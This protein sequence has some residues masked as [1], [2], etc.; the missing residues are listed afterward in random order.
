MMHVASHR[1]LLTE[2]T[3]R[4]EM[5][6]VP[7]VTFSMIFPFVLAE[8]ITLAAVDIPDFATQVIRFLELFRANVAVAERGM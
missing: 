7:T 5:L 1:F 6:F 2:E 3:L 4:K 8:G